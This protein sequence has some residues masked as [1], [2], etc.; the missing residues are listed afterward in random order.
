MALLAAVCP[1]SRFPDRG[2]NAWSEKHVAEAPPLI[3]SP[4]FGANYRVCEGGSLSIPLTATGSGPLS[5]QWYQDGLPIMGN[6]TAFTSTLTIASATKADVG[7]Y[8][9]EVTNAEGKDTID[10]VLVVD[11]LEWPAQRQP[12]IQRDTEISFRSSCPSQV[13]L[14]VKQL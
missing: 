3:T 14:Q 12:H 7:I 5:Y 10:V 13:H 2:S 1:G 6:P 8:S 4:A 11:Y 9:C